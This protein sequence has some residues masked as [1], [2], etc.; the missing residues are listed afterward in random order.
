MVLI[1]WIHAAWPSAF[2][3]GPWPQ[4]G[5][6]ASENLGEQSSTPITVGCEAFGFDDGSAHWAGALPLKPLQ[7]ATVA[8]DVVAAELDGLLHALLQGHSEVFAG[9]KEGM[10][11]ASRWRHH[12][13][14][15][16]FQ[17]EADQCL[18]NGTCMCRTIRTLC[19]S[20]LLHCA[21]RSGRR[22]GSDEST[23]H[24]CV[25]DH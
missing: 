16:V 20:F 11:E 12:S 4:G 2:G 8:E 22:W 23:P 25:V 9:H 17:W 10:F 3:A 24:F 19:T 5:C 21:G 13:N 18:I 14:G 7:D 1:V 15:G 6:L